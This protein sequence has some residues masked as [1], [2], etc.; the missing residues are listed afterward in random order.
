[1]RR[2]ALLWVFLPLATTADDLAPLPIPALDVE[3]NVRAMLEQARQ[4]AHDAAG[5]VLQPASPEPVAPAS[6]PAKTSVQPAITEDPEPAPAA[7]EST[8]VPVPLK[9]I[10]V[11]DLEGVRGVAD[12]LENARQQAPKK[13]LE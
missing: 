4:A 9:T 1:M 10:T 5:P 13:T 11:R 3:A 7:A 2:A 12:E 6:A 8:H